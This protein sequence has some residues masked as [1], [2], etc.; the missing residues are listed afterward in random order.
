MSADILGCH[1]SGTG[2][3]RHT[4]GIL[5]VE[6]KNVT[7]PTSYNAQGTDP[8][9]KNCLDPNVNTAHIGKYG[10]KGVSHCE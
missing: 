9:T 10:L 1:N 7:C 3:W 5:W 6:D 2:W 8:M 4:Y